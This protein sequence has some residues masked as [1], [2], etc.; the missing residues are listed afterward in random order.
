MTAYYSTNRK[1]AEV[2]LDQA[3]LQGQAGDRGLYLPRPLPA[4]SPELL[5]RARDLPYPEL[6]ASFLEPFA[7]GVFTREVLTEIC[8]DAYDFDL[9]LEEVEPRRWVLRLDRGPTASFKDF[10]ARFMGRALGRLV[11]ERNQELLILTAT[12]GDTG[13]AIAHAFFRVPSIRVLVLF[14]IKEVSDRQRKQM[15][16]LGEN[17]A[18]VAVAGKTS[19]GTTCPRPTR[20]TSGGSSPRPCTTSTPLPRRPTLPPARG[21]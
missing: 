12:S 5:A 18:T 11:T 15:T 7:E 19:R 4:L 1:A 9:P 13:S 16:T 10:A 6:A 20:S 3:L 14:P 8:E 17:V 21:R 2:G